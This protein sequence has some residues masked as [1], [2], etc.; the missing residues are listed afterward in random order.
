MRET[1]NLSP[2]SFDK[3]GQRQKSTFKITIQTHKKKD[4]IKW[5]C[6]ALITALLLN[7]NMGIVFLKEVLISASH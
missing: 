3:T 2:V 6:F 7:A 4:P 1:T 5:H